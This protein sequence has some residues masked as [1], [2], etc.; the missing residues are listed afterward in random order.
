MTGA[1]QL[2]QIEWYCLTCVL[3]AGG[4]FSEL[5]AKKDRVT[6]IGHKSN[7]VSVAR[8]PCGSFAEL[9][10]ID[11]FCTQVIILLL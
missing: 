5:K 3:Q 8:F 1:L 10:I 6:V 9:S 4:P 2:P 7:R 11:I